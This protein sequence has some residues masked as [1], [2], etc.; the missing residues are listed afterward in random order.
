[1]E[2]L[3]LLLG[4]LTPPLLAVRDDGD[5]GRLRVA[6]RL[7]QRR[8]A[9]RLG[10]GLDGKPSLEGLG[11]ERG[12]GDAPDRTERGAHPRGLQAGAGILV[13][14]RSSLH[15]ESVG[16][17]ELVRTKPPA[18]RDVTPSAASE[19]SPLVPGTAGVGGLAVCRRSLQQ[20]VVQA[21]RPRL[22]HCGAAGVLGT[23]A[24]PAAVT[25]LQTNIS[26]PRSDTRLIQV[27]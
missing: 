21:G 25:E 13:S 11:G 12:V 10:Q 2:V 4:L 26:L 27:H 23:E 24:A 9:G 22:A 14:H 1:M 17:Q 19:D 5:V 18:Q 6:P 7:D 3:L 8:V 15:R 16:G 20:P